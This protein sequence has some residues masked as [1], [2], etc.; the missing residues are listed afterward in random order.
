MTQG[1]NLSLDII[2]TLA[3]IIGSIAASYAVTRHRAEAAQKEASEAKARADAV[4][5]QLSD[6]K[7]EATKRF[8][9]DEMLQSV[10]SKITE[11][12]NRLADRLDRII[13]GGRKGWW[14][15]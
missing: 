8:A 3:T 1:I 12:I 9:T 6:F 10:E 7:I 5:G 14:Q 4:A 11:A 13:E 2:I 15:R